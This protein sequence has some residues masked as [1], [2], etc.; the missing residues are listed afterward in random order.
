[1]ASNNPKEE[2]KGNYIWLNGS[3]RL[4]PEMPSLLTHQTAFDPRWMIKKYISVVQ[5]LMHI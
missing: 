5:S 1:M 4:Y 3:V 2:S